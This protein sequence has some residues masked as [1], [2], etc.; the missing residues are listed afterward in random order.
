MEERKMTKVFC[1]QACDGICC[2]ADFYVISMPTHND[3]LIKKYF[4]TTDLEIISMYKTTYV[5]QCEK[6]EFNELM[7]ERRLFLLEL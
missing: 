2:D 7:N 1:K 3:Q 5:P 4:N 6:R